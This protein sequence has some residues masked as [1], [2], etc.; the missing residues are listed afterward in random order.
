MDSNV[1]RPEGWTSADAA[2]LATLPGLVRYD[3]VFSGQPINHAFRVTV[4][5]STG[6][7]FPGSHVAGS[8]TSALRSGPPKV[9]SSVWMI[10]LEPF[11]THTPSSPHP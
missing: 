8:N 2:G 5:D 10:S 3:E 11:A 7:A 4:R 6:Y 9:R 1:R